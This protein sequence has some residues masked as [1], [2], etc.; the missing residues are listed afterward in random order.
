MLSEAKKRDVQR[1]R[2]QMRIRK[3]VRGT[4]EKPRFSVFKSNKHIFAQLIDDEQ[5]KTIV[6][7]GTMSSTCKGKHEKKSKEAARFIGED[8]ARV[9]KEKNI[10]RVVFDRGRYKY[11]G[12]IAAI[13][14]AARESGLQF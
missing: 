7:L 9:A 14:D 13:A 6:S 5:G 12:L 11:H 8:M 10:A 4:L 1:H 2:R 3:R